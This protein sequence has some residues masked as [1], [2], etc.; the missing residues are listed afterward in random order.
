MRKKKCEEDYAYIKLVIINIK[1]KL[2]ETSQRDLILI[3][4]GSKYCCI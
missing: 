4:A 3:E 1:E 2:Y